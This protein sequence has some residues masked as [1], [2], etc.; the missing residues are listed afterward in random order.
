MDKLWRTVLDGLTPEHWAEARVELN[1]MGDSDLERLFQMAERIRAKH[2][3]L[4][5]QESTYIALRCW[6]KVAAIVEHPDG[7]VEILRSWL[8]AHPPDEDLTGPLPLEV[9]LALSPEEA[10]LPQGAAA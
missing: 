4:T 7:R 3:D 9:M 1:E 5:V 8:V 2:P 10:A 6:P